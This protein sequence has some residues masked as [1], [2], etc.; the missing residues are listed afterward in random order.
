MEISAHVL[1]AVMTIMNVETAEDCRKLTLPAEMAM[2]QHQEGGDYDPS[3][4]RELG[5]VSE[6]QIR[7]VQLLIPE[8]RDAPRRWFYDGKLTETIKFGVTIML[9]CEW[10]LKRR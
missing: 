4:G 8:T 5:W 9:E 3:L 2:G 10:S 7:A 1:A 6:R